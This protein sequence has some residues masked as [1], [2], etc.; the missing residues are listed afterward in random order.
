MHAVVTY[1]IGYYTFEQEIICIFSRVEN[2]TLCTNRD[3]LLRLN[4]IS[5][6]SE[7]Y[8]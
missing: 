4:A 7:A 1:E 8:I 2:A 5:T 6:F 3:N